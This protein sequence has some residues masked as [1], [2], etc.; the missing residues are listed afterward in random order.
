[1]KGMQLS[2]SGDG[3]DRRWELN[4]VGS[5][6]RS[7]LRWSKSMCTEEVS[8]SYAVEAEGLEIALLL[9]SIHKDPKEPSKTRACV[10]M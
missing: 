9:A 7:K 3:W 10:K 5:R 6:H 8:G 4:D 2:R 1:M